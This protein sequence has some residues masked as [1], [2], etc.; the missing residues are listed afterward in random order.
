MTPIGQRV[1][2]FAYD[3][4]S[5]AL[6]SGRAA[7]QDVMIVAIDNQSIEELGPWPWPR[8]QLARL[9][10]Q[11]AKGK[12]RAIV[13]DI[14]LPENREGD[15]ALAAAMSR[16]GN[17]VLP[18]GVEAPGRNG[19]AFD[20][21]APVPELA[22]SART[23]GHASVTPDRDG[24][25]R[26]ID[27][28]IT[29]SAQSLP[30]IATATVRAFPA[31]AGALPAIP[32]GVAGRLRFSVPSGGF[33]TV[34]AYAVLGGQVPADYFLGRDVLVGSIASGLGDTYATPMGSDRENLA[35][36]ELVGNALLAERSNDYIGLPSGWELATG[37]LALPI[38]LALAFL[39]VGPTTI[40]ALSALSLA[41]L[42]LAALLGLERGVW[43]VPTPAAVGIVFAAT[44][45]TWRRLKYVDTALTDGLDRIGRPATA[46]I[47]SSTSLLAD[48]LEER[49]TLLQ[50]GLLSIRQRQLSLD[51]LVR[52]LPD[53]TFRVDPRGRITLVNAVFRGL[54]DQLDTAMPNS[55]DGLGE[56]LLP[57][58][59]RGPASPWAPVTLTDQGLQV[60]D[61]EIRDRLGRF[62][63]IAAEELGSRAG[64]VVSLSDITRVRQ[65]TLAQRRSLQFLS[66]D[67]RS[68]IAASISLIDQIDAAQSAAGDE[69]L[70]QIRV[71][72]LDALRMS[73]E[74]VAL[75]KAEE[76]QTR[77]AVFDLTA[78]AEEAIDRV[79]PLAAGKGVEIVESWHQNEVFEALG[80]S[81]EV[82]RAISNL[83]MNAVNHAAHQIARVTVSIV[84]T[85]KS[86][87]L[88]VADTDPTSVL[89]IRDALAKFTA[90]GELARGS[91]LGLAYCATVIRKAGGQIRVLR[92]A[93][94][95][96]V[97]LDFPIVD[98]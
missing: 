27:R 46:G 36:V 15:E 50:Q 30:H 80:D 86:V 37:T 19:A 57:V 6:V 2:T 9:V 75:T 69:R 83:V 87:R 4:A 91:G 72:L 68:P 41:L 84:R 44:T 53:P 10:D 42:A 35:G 54:F 60:T 64:W 26:A 1:D 93:H 38:L 92:T 67:L 43:L 90:S 13:L 17:V 63:I 97:A 23:V 56:A 70:Q 39:R 3:L 45:W 22:K 88:T 18:V 82:S 89:S 59:T 79:S 66:H 8:V 24:I 61:L 40:V 58:E 52:S 74:H 47:A 94:G 48:P 28:V 98:S 76:R 55:I 65:V 49:V 31:R 5:R 78:C 32:P 62:Y 11:I 71:R 33:Q 14:L 96:E 21:I 85:T 81:S 34:P 51:D 12:P 7:P 25:V 95:K 73:D 77:K 20:L 29:T 16:A